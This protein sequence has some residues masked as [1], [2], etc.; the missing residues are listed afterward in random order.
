MQMALNWL[1]ILV[2][3]SALVNFGS[4]LKLV[5]SYEASLPFI[6]SSRASFE[7][8][9]RVPLAVALLWALASASAG[10]ANAPVNIA[11]AT[12]AVA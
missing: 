8:L 5:A 10:E 4:C 3:I 6:D 1:R 7:A 2:K 9:V 12:P 11:A